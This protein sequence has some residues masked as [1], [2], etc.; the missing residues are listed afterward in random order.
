MTPES[1]YIAK[2]AASWLDDFLVW[3]S[4]EAF[5]CCRKF[6]N[7]SYCPPDDQVINPAS[8]I[9]LIV[10]MSTC[11]FPLRFKA[12]FFFFWFQPPCCTSGQSSCGLTGPCT[13]CT[14]VMYSLLSELEVSCLMAVYVIFPSNHVKICG[15]VQCFHHSDLLNDRPSTEQ[16]K[17]KLP[18]FLNALPSADCAKGGHGAYTSGVDLKGLW[19]IFIYIYDYF[20]VDR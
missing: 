10:E 17:E 1:S 12:N 7:G 18:W 14:T 11:C 20:Q 15:N 8:E 9:D 16:F 6:T 19:R 2:P 13:D 4:P 5:G 3:I